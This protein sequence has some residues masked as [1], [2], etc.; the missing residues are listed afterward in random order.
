MPE[1]RVIITAIVVRDG[2]SSV[3]VVQV[4]QMEEQQRPLGGDGLVGPVVGGP[5]IAAGTE[6]EPEG[7]G[8]RG[9]GTEGAA[10]ERFVAQD[11]IDFDA[12][13][14][15]GAR[16]QPF[17]VQPDDVALRGGGGDRGGIERRPERGAGADR[18]TDL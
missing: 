13:G 8:A 5:P 4:A 18:E 6:G 1:H 10:R 3:T 17:D 7:G 14:V 12:V 2:R 15:G 11:P 9:E 16:L